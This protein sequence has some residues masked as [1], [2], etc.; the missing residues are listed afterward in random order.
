LQTYMA[1]SI[2]VSRVAA[3]QARFCDDIQSAPRLT[4]SSWGQLFNPFECADEG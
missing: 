1:S 2:F 4:L 3:T